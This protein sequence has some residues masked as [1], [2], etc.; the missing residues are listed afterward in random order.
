VIAVRV[1]AVKVTA[2]NVLAATVT[3]ENL[4]T[5]NVTAAKEEFDRA[6]A[7]KNLDVSLPVAVGH[8][9]CIDGGEA[10]VPRRRRE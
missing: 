6:D 7:R 5:V 8:T 9:A 4:T 10:N 3:A 2:A 1:T